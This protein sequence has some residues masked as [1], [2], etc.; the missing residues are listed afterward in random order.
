MTAAFAEHGTLAKHLDGFRPRD[1]QQQMAQAVTQAIEN[2]Q[3]LV[4]EAGTGTGKTYAYLVP[5]LL[6][7]KKVILSTGTKNLQE[8]LYLRDLPRVQQALATPVQTA[9]LKGRSNY[10]CLFR[11]EQH[12]HHVPVQDPQLIQDLSLIKKWAAE[13]HTGDTGELTYI[14]EDSKALPYVTST[15]DNC[16]GKDCP[17][18]DDCYL[19]KA[20]KKAQAADLVVVNHHLFFADL[21]LKDT[22]FGELLPQ[23]EVVIFDEAHQ[24]PDIASDYFGEHVS[25]RLLLELCRDIDICCKTELKDHPQLAKTADKL[26]SLVR[27]WRLL[28]P[29]EPQKGNWRELC[30]RPDMQVSL[31]RVNDAIEMLYQVLKSSLGRSDVL[32]NCFERLAQARNRL[33]KLTDV[34]Q[35]GVSLWFETTRQHVS[36]HLTPLSIADKFNQVVFNQQ[37]S[38]IFTSATLSVDE[39]FS[40]YTEQ[41]GLQQAQTL[42]L[43]SPFDYQR[44]SLLCV[45]RFLPEPH[46]PAMLPA[47]LKLAVEL[48]KTNNG[49][50]FFLFTSHRMLQQIADLLPAEVSQPILVQG[51]TSK[52]ILL[53]QFVKLDNAVLL[54][55]GSFWEGVDVRGDTLSCVI[56]D[57]LPFASPDDPLLQARSEDCSLKG[58]DPFAE[59]QLPQ[60]VITLKQGVGRLIRDVT[61]RGVLVICDNR[62][63]TKPYGAVFLKSLPPMRRSRSLAQATEFLKQIQQGKAE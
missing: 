4:V 9:L 61:D 62:L 63:V 16:L 3:A 25:S 57:K 44:Q 36:L 18:Y 19:V 14:A 38:W 43:H 55:T 59:V 7:G 39:G 58:K 21:A 6:A 32:D 54:G 20:R 41:M 50:C 42:L 1:A 13:T 24:L 53:E 60:A 22:G 45:P 11:L 56:I 33:L 27:D 10:L 8:Q 47:L 48:I 31:G 51:S 15:T 46:Q 23:M 17:V 37:R 30:L 2:T 52:R 26:V 28:F 12:Y 34:Q 49:R 40:H 35:N 5:A 29:A